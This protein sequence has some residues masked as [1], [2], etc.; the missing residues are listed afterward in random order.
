MP[1]SSQIFEAPRI[2]SKIYPTLDVSGSMSGAEVVER[3]ST[4]TG[5]NYDAVSLA[6]V[7][8]LHAVLAGQ[9]TSPEAAAALEKELVRITGFEPARK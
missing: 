2:V 9:S 3:P 5:A 6:Y 8:A 7:Q 1:K 4:L